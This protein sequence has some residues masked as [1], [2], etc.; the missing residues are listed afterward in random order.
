MCGSHCVV[1][2]DFPGVRRACLLFRQFTPCESDLSYCRVVNVPVATYRRSVVFTQ[3]CPHLGIGGLFFGQ[4]AINRSHPCYF[5]ILYS[6]LLWDVKVKCGWWSAVGYRLSA[7][8][9]VGWVEWDVKIGYILEKTFA[10]SKNVNIQK[11][12]RN[13]TLFFTGAFYVVGFR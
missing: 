7:I 11:R 13:P 4:K 9:S 3:R 10:F 5:S 1:T 6:V 12:K 8:Q 2:L